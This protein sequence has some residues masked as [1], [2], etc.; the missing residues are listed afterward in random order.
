MKVS[1]GLDG[2]HEVV[3]IHLMERGPSNEAS[4][5]LRDDRTFD[6]QVGLRGNERTVLGGAAQ[7]D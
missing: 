5:L 2:G 1:A 6:P 3:N 4:V 7:Y